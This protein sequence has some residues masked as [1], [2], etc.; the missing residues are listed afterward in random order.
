[1]QYT[2]QL[3]NFKRLKSYFLF[4]IGATEE[5]RKQP[6]QARAEPS[7]SSICPP[8]PDAMWWN[9]IYKS[10]IQEC[11]QIATQNPKEERKKKKILISK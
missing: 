9:H 2:I 1:M 7:A 8:Q 5:T 11:S 10:S 3:N 4:H 6:H